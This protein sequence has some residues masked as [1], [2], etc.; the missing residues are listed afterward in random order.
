MTIPFLLR[1]CLF[2]ALAASALAQ[3]PATGLTVEYVAAHPELWP[4]QVITKGPAQVT[5]QTAGSAPVSMM[6]PAGELLKVVGVA[7]TTVQLEFRGAQLT[8]PAAQTDLL[9]GAASNLVRLAAAS[10]PPPAASSP[11]AAGPAYP[12]GPSAPP[13]PQGS[14][15]NPIVKFLGDS[16]IAF[17]G[18][19]VTRQPSAQLIGKK[20]VAFYFA[21]RSA[22]AC[23]VFTAKLKQFYGAHRRDSDKFEIVF[24]PTD[25]S[26]KEMA[27]H[28]R[29]AEMPWL[30]VDFARGEIV[31]GLRQQFGGTEVPNLVVLDESGRLVVSSSDGK[32]F[33]GADKALE[34][35]GRL[36]DQS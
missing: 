16:L 15:E 32:T 13:R 21:T 3:A 20:Y 24:V 18:D 23:K 11:A 4:K 22:D 30:A 25:K 7:G 28:I 8:M 1:P 12:T 19:S 14:G 36:L 27:Y 2:L 6:M 10:R 31:G 9:A 29:E 26:A 33:V 17:R 5:L 35:F 34:E